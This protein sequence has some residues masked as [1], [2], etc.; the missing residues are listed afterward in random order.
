MYKTS[1]Q[2][3]HVWWGLLAFLFVSF[4]IAD[5]RRSLRAPTVSIVACPTPT[6]NTLPLFCLT[7]PRVHLRL[8]LPRLLFPSSLP[9]SISV[10]RF[11]ALI[12]WP[13][14]WSLRRCTV[15]SRRS[16][17]CTSCSTD[18]LIRYAVQLTL[19]NRRY[20]VISKPCIRLLSTAFSVHVGFLGRQI[21]ICYLNDFQRSNGSCHDNQILGKSK[22]K[23]HYN[24]ISRHA[25][26]QDELLFWS[27]VVYVIRV[28]VQL[29]LIFPSIQVFKVGCF[30][31]G[32]LMSAARLVRAHLHWFQFYTRY[33]EFFSRE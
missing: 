21:Q 28:C 16:C 5:G 2:F 13:K 11:L 9:S 25:P 15:V 1:R 19:S 23:L 8:G 17:G 18:A 7:T 22:P 12:I 29:E 26:L 10:H 33:R 31:V 3:L 30:S 32:W 20:A 14:Y 27:F 4:L 6:V 24:S